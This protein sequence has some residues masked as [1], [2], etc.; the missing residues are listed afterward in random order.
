MEEL[1]AGL[2]AGNH[3]LAV[4]VA[5]MPELI[6]GYGHVKARHLLAVRAQWDALMARWRQ[7]PPSVAD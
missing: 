3:A 2:H 5:R 7:V 6:R 1:L 4:E